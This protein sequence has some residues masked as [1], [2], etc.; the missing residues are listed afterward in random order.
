MNNDSTNNNFIKSSSQITNNVSEVSNDIPKNIYMCN[1][2]IGL[3]EKIMALKWKTLNPDY[4]I[5]LYSDYACAEFIKNN[6]NNHFLK[7]FLA[8]KDG[9]IRADFWRLCIL[10]KKGGIYS[11]IDNLPYVAIKDFI[12][13]DIDL[14]TCI[15]DHETLV[16]NPNLIIVKPNNDIIKLV[17]DWY[18][19]RSKKVQY[20]YWN[21]SIMV[22][23][24]YVLQLSN[25]N[26]KGG[27]YNYKNNKIQLLNEKKNNDMYKFNNFYK[28]KKIFKNRVN[29]WDYKN[30]C[31]KK[32]NISDESLQDINRFF[33]INTL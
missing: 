4:K 14:V 28:N 8:L 23:F 33:I 15:A 31:F 13:K 30:H 24:S 32:K 27:V 17:L 25:F 26:K 5:H 20:S 11:D 22:A 7:C 18:I 2:N 19:E 1:N 16:Y 12:E 21:Y 29:G 10:Y 3:N 6:F 9:P